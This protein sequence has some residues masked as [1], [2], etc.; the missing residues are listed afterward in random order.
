ME[1]EEIK[2][3]VL[4]FLGKF[5]KK[6][7]RFMVFKILEVKTLVESCLFIEQM[8]KQKLRVGKRFAQGHAASR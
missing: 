4:Y 6:L 1:S 7:W 8:R 5:H 2:S 3:I